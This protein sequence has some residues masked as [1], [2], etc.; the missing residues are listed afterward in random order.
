MDAELPG[1][2]CSAPQDVQIERDKWRW[3]NGSD[4]LKGNVTPSCGTSPSS[5]AAI[6]A[7]AR[8]SSQLLPQGRFTLG[9]GHQHCP[10]VW[11]GIPK[12]DSP[13]EGSSSSDRFIILS[14]CSSHLQYALGQQD[15]SSTGGAQVCSRA[16]LCQLPAPALALPQ[17]PGSSTAGIHV[18][19]A[20]CFPQLDNSCQALPHP[21]CCQWHFPC[22]CRRAWCAEGSRCCAWCESFLLLF[23]LGMAGAA[24]L[25]LVLA[26]FSPV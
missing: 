11:L 5:Q 17:P 2:P 9:R 25:S 19:T 10:G 24:L 12:G 20:Q 6:A 15:F 23:V 18:G 8:S 22:S 14:L 26:G 4:Q 7:G 3:R 16:V 21:C 13:L 1:C